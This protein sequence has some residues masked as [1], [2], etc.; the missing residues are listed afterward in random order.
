MNVLTPQ[1][2][3]PR[4][5]RDLAEGRLNEAEVEA[6]ADWLTAQGLSEPPE[7]VLAR[8]LQVGHQIGAGAA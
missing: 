8:G 4:L 5:F 7:S 3:V 1:P 2:Q 6:L